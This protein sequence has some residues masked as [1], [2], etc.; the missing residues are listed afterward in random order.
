MH[1]FLLAL[2][3]IPLGDAGAELRTSFTVPSLALEN[4]VACL[5]YRQLAL[6]LLESPESQVTGTSLVSLKSILP[7]E[8]ISCA[9]DFLK[10]FE[11]T[12]TLPHEGI[13]IET[14]TPSGVP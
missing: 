14:R 2:V 9:N 12:N 1:L 6:G 5:V 7:L 10:D 3:F 4:C 8:L 11:L 13:H